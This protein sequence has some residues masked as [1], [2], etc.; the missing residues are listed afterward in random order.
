MLFTDLGL[1]QELVHGLS[2]AGLNTALPIQVQAIPL[3]LDRQS[4]MLISR[5]GSGKTLAYLLPVLAKLDPAKPL[6]QAV[7]LAPTHELAMQIYRVAANVVQ[8]SGLDMRVQALIGGVA[9][10]RQLEGLKKKP[11]LIV[12]SA[13]RIVHFLELK[14]LKLAQMDWLVF[15][16]TDRLLVEDKLKNI[17]RI[18]QAK[19]ALTTC[20]F[21]S[22][23]KD[24]RTTR[25]AQEL[26][27]DL[28]LVEVDEE[29]I[30]PAIRHTYLI[31]E[32]RDKID[33]VRKIVRGLQSARTL[34]FVHRGSTAQDMVPKLT[35]H[36]LHVADLHG[37]HDKLARQKA[38]E[39]FRRGQSQILVASD[40]AARGLD[41]DGVELVINFDAPSQSRDYLHR[42][43]RTGRGEAP[44]L[45][46]TLV[47]KAEERLMQRYAHDLGIVVQ[48][49]ALIRGRLE[50]DA[51]RDTTG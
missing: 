44:G 48:P 21:V 28:R 22:A 17:Q 40:I 5:T 51:T 11:Q 18:A 7:V 14:K 49:V 9:S 36:G 42:A 46:I 35:Y 30:N 43:G 10:K 2:H 33:L 6:V 38:L 8:Q 45:V 25:I 50:Q 16:E 39:V 19:S 27:P 37:A 41:I 29:Q 24:P 34:V 20:V 13:G 31:C 1:S 15:D 12:G 23:T 47:T 4:A 3:L 32:Q 26:A